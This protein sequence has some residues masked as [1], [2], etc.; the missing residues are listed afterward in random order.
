LSMIIT[1]FDCE[2][3]GGVTQKW[4]AVRIKRSRCH[5]TVN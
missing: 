3:T 4:V 1:F 2:I 5:L